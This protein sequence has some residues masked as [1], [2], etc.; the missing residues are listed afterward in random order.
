MMLRVAQGLWAVVLTCGVAPLATAQPSTEG[1]ARYEVFF[2]VDADIRNLELAADLRAGGRLAALSQ[3]LPEGGRRLQL[4]RPLVDP[5]KFYWVDPAGPAGEE[6]KYA[7]V[8]TLEE[9]T[10]EA[11]DRADALV[12]QRGEATHER[13]RQASGNDHP[14]DGA[15]AFV[16]IGP[17]EGRF[18]IDLEPDGRLRG[19]RNRLTS[20]WQPG[21]FDRFLM[22]WAGPSFEGYWFWNKG[23]RQPPQWEPHTYHAF[24]QAL[25]LLRLPAPPAPAVDVDWEDAPSLA[26]DV[27]TTLAP[28][29]AARL[30]LPTSW[31]LTPLPLTSRQDGCVAAAMVGEGA[32]VER[33]LCGPEGAAF[34]DSDRVRVTLAAPGGRLDVEV[35]Y[36][37]LAE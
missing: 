35:G 3:A 16:V 14:F 1:A 30:T 7:S 28:R 31:Q 10:W 18:D 13:W 25:E 6:A 11:F 19:V 12:R 2:R 23:N 29:T 34:P 32:S 5:W 15:F 33:T 21:P 37:P 20:R 26:I 27:V 22:Q 36:R 8:V 9:G 24:E 17:P 4:T